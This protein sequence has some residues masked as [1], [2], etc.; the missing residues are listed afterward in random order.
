MNPATSEFWPKYLTYYKTIFY[1]T[2][3]DNHFSSGQQ[4][5]ILSYT[6]QLP[7]TRFLRKRPLLRKTSGSYLVTQVLNTSQTINTYLLVNTNNNCVIPWKTDITSK[8]WTP[9]R[10]LT[11]PLEELITTTFHLEEHIITMT[12][13]TAA[14]KMM[15]AWCQ[16]KHQWAQCAK[17]WRVDCIFFFCFP[18]RTLGVNLLTFF[19]VCECSPIAHVDNWWL[20]AWCKLSVSVAANHPSRIWTSR[21]L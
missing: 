5:F 18:Y 6:W 15:T 16:W 12:S 11:F 14:N 3:V 1:K 2:K 19:C 7:F 8:A 17:R 10:S 20:Q 4:L 21:S 9:E 13:I